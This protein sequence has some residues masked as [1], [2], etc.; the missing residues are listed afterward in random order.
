MQQRTFWYMIKKNECYP[1]IVKGF[2]LLPYTAVHLHV[3][4]VCC[5]RVSDNHKNLLNYEMYHVGAKYIY[6]VGRDD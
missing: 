4:P 6:S 3:M 1:Y 2:K 5:A